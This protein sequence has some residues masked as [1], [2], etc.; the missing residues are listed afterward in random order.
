MHLPGADDLSLVAVAHI[1]MHD[2]T[3]LGAFLFFD[4]RNAR[5]QLCHPAETT[6]Q[7][8][9]F[10]GF[11]R[12]VGAVDCRGIGVLATTILPV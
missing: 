3:F 8:P 9:G 6:I 7:V 4:D 11:D 10:D 12:G 1:L 2:L 5:V